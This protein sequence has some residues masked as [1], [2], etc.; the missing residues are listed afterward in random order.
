MEHVQTLAERLD[1]IRNS[2]LDKLQEEVIQLDLVN[3]MPTTFLDSLSDK[4]RAICL[5]ASLVCY[6][7]TGATQIPREMQLKG[8]LANLNGKDCLIIA[9]TGSGKTL[10][11]ALCI[12]LDDPA[13]KLVTLTLSP[14][15]R[16]QITQEN[17]FNTRYGISTVCINEDTPRDENWWNVL[18]VSFGFCY[19]HLLTVTLG[20]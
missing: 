12:L 14:L 13:K 16:L 7:V 4:D 1:D 10:P 9:G 17:D 15:K 8:L 2:P 20:A 6:C 18:N 3:R 11:I 5:R 19:I